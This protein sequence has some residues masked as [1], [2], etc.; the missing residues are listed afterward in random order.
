MFISLVGLSLEHDLLDNFVSYQPPELFRDLKHA[1]VKSYGGNTANLG[2]KRKY[3]CKPPTLLEL[4]AELLA[5]I[6]YSFVQ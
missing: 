1:A 4:Q 6:W 3:V 2:G 5:F